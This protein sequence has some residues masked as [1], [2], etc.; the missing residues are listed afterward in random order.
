MSSR[1]KSIC[2]KACAAAALFVIIAA[3][4]F[5]SRYRDLKKTLLDSLSARATFVAGQRVEIGD[6]SLSPSTLDISNIR[7]ENPAGFAPGDL[8]RIRLMSVAL[9]LAALLEGKLHIRDIEVYYPELSME[10]DREGKWNISERLI[11]LLSEKKKP[12]FKYRI[13]EVRI[14]S[15]IFEFNENGR[16]RNEHIDARLTGLSSEEGT[17][18]IINGST[19]LAGNKMDIAAWAYLNDEPK[20]FM[21]TVAAKAFSFSAFH[22]LLERY[23]VDAEK[24]NLDFSFAAEG[25]T[26]SGFRIRSDITARKAAIPFFGDDSQ[27]VRL[28]AD[29]FFSPKDSRL[30]VNGASLHAGEGTSI[31]LKGEVDNIGKASRYSAEVLVKKADLSAVRFFKGIRMRGFVTSPGINL[32]GKAGGGLP[33]IAGSAVLNDVSVKSPDIDVDRINGE[34]RFSPARGFSVQARTTADI[35][36]AGA[37]LPAKPARLRLTLSASKE[38]GGISFS[39]SAIISSFETDTGENRKISA[40]STILNAD[41][42]LMEKKLSCRGTI[43]VKDLSYSGHSVPLLR[44]SSSIDADEHRLLVKDLKIGGRGLTAVAALIQL[45]P[46]RTGERYLIKITGLDA[47]YPEEKAAIDGLDLS[48]ALRREKTL[49]GDIALSARK[50]LFKGIE[51]ARIAGKGG[52][53]GKNFHLEVPDADIFR[54]KMHITAQGKISRDHFP[55]SITAGADNV[56][57]EA[58]S[59]AASSSV[60]FPYTLSGRLAH[61][62][63]EGTISSPEDIRGRASLSASGVSAA[64][65]DPKKTLVKDVS[66]DAGMTFAGPDF[67]FGLNVTAGSVPAKVSGEVKR[68]TGKER[69]FAV[70]VD[71]PEVKADAVR[72][73]FWDI[74]PDSLLY[75]GLAGSLSSHLEISGSKGILRAIGDLTLKD[76]ALTGENDEYFLGPVNGV[77]PVGYARLAAEEQA[78]P[79]PS[80]DRSEFEKLKRIYSQK[81]GEPGFNMITIGSIRYGFRLLEDISLLVKQQDGVFTIGSFS[82]NIFGGKL[83]GSAV[84]TAS[85]GLGYRGGA[86]IDGLSLKR[87]C[88]DI[89]PIKGYISGKV[90]GVMMIKGSG[91][92]LSGLIGKGDFWTYSSGG[93]KTKIS[94]KFLRTIAGPSLKSYVGDRSFDRGVMSFYLQNGFLIFRQ[95]EISNRNFFGM[96][97]LSVKVAPYNNRIAID[98]LMWSITEAAQRAKKE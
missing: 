14:R 93:E 54:G 73:S 80:F 75:T 84:I 38:R 42:G 6:L 51:A 95:L 83:N 91:F 7:I 53:D 2:K 67:S 57:L 4:F 30:T 9:D 68:F 62:S 71:L 5:Y 72:D 87:V 65:K 56:D 96:T 63:L 74:F 10:R 44:A 23:K 94:R 76:F 12:T 88:D 45:I 59:K 1:A 17:K 31:S 32:R 43:E 90:N 8:L 16:L 64:G 97:D 34:L 98:R 36:K 85:G 66:V 61:A 81:G 39:S 46:D 60:H 47:A 69:T 79:L 82:A 33:E 20:K 3:F 58:L 27:D 40:G 35:A 18:T 77:I 22:D 48:L 49:S 19:V 55:L 37:F 50:V 11:R 78:V 26:G 29:A 92:G 13:D 89:E 25:D 70:K 86:M 15:G 21:L 24:M 41:G 28:M 52:F